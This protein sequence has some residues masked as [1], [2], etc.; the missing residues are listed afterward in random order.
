MFSQ[1]N[2]FFYHQSPVNKDSRS[3]SGPD[4][5]TR[6][7]HVTQTTSLNSTPRGSSS[8]SSYLANNQ[9]G[10]EHRGPSRTSFQEH[11]TEHFPLA[12]KKR[13]SI[14]SMP[15][16]RLKVS[17]RPGKLENEWFVIVK[18]LE[19]SDI[20]ES[21]SNSAEDYERRTRQKHKASVTSRL[22]AD[23]ALQKLSQ[24]E[25]KSTNYYREN[26]CRS[27]STDFLMVAVT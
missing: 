22:A 9:L 4:E 20:S 23:G 26:K 11:F 7:L 5:E 16:F 6:L 3:P 10:P 24:I 2:R 27:S 21:S 25:K 19:M 15:I 8:S 17:A 12:E 14:P 13:K 1:V 18:T